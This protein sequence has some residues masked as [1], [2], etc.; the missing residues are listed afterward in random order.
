M[1]I[2]V[3]L[4]GVADSR[5]PLH[6]VSL[7]GNGDLAETG[8]T[9]R[10]LGPFDEGALELA[11][12]LR[13]KSETTRVHVLVLGGPNEDALA[14]TVA[15]FKPDS[16]RV[17]E[18]QPCRPWDS[19]LTASQLGAFI[20]SDNSVPDLVFVGREFGDLD[21]GSI[22]VLLAGELEMPMFP[23]TQFAQWRGG[24]EQEQEQEQVRLM[25]ER[26][27][28]REWLALDNT[29]YLATVTNDKRNKLRHPL[30]KNVMMAKKQPVDKV[31]QATDKAAGVTATSMTDPETTERNVQCRM[32]E[33]S[34]QD[35]AAAIAD[36]I[37]QA[38]G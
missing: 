24:Q 38:A 4:A 34:V 29:S 7:D 36:Y 11:L 30:M 35:Q 28:S 3:L 22:P 37:R 5:Y 26:G 16:L 27:T 19:A 33:G 2:L 15:A 32:L 1:D 8:Q 31:C 20:R 21:E 13:D 25:R 17:L 9:R 10:V 12:K 6:E 23:L 14:R 18:L